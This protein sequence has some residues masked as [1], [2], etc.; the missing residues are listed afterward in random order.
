MFRWTRGS[1][2]SNIYQMGKFTIDPSPARGK[3]Q[4]PGIHRP[5]YPGTDRSNLV[6]RYSKFYWTS[7][8][9]SVDPCQRSLSRSSWWKKFNSTSSCSIWGTLGKN[10]N[11]PPRL[12]W[13]PRNFKILFFNF[14]LSF[15]TEIHNGPYYMANSRIRTNSP[16]L[17]FSRF[18]IKRPFR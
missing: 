4:R 5:P 15:L 3:N 2:G 6:R 17:W 10:S 8:F 14:N 7:Q 11:L 13:I 12:G 16:I 18:S 9:W 1:P